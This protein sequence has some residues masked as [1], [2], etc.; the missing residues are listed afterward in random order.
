MNEFD[1]NYN[2]THN[3]TTIETNDIQQFLCMHVEIV[4]NN[5]I[6]FDGILT[7]HDIEEIKI[8]TGEY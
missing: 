1:I 5:E 3:N 7:Q 4:F 6:L 8:E 2:V